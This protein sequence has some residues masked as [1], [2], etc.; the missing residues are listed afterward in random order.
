MRK[1]LAT[2]NISVAVAS[3]LIA[4]P[5]HA[6]FIFGKK[7]SERP[8]VEKKTFKGFD[9]EKARVGLRTYESIHSVP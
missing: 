8:M 3:V 5:A 7:T 9:V 2:V 6:D 4:A 1:N